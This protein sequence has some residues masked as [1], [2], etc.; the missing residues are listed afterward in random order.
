[1][2]SLVISISRCSAWRRV[3]KRLFFSCTFDTDTHTMMQINNK[4]MRS[5]NTSGQTIASTMRTRFNCSTYVNV[6]AGNLKFVP[7]ITWRNEKM[8][9]L[10]PDNSTACK[11]VHVLTVTDTSP[12]GWVS[13]EQ[14][15]YKEKIFL[16]QSQ[17]NKTQTYST[18]T[19]RSSCD[20]DDGANFSTNPHPYF[21]L[22]N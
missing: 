12:G 16:C 17:N 7:I 21:I 3:V 14:T 6:P 5:K 1:M 10:S 13:G 19:Y 22:M 9:R 20:A 2:H 15:I 18:W 8:V 11:T 4:L